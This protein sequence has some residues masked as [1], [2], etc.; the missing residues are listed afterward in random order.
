MT[1]SKESSVIFNGNVKSYSE[2]STDIDSIVWLLKRNDTNK[3]VLELP[4]V[5]VI[6]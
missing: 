4:C 5:E 3:C 6:I 1:L 2:L